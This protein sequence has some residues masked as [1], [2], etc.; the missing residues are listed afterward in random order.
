[1]KRVHRRKEN[2]GD[3]PHPSVLSTLENALSLEGTEKAHSLM[4]GGGV[5][6][7]TQGGGEGH[8]KRQG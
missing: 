1:M 2:P 3:G 4:Y 5:W 7:I 6:A 8:W